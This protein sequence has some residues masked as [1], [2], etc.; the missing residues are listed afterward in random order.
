M[1]TPAARSSQVGR[2]RKSA[3]DSVSLVRPVLGMVRGGAPL[4]PGPGRA[5]R[6]SA[7]TRGDRR[8]LRWRRSGPRARKKNRGGSADRPGLNE[9]EDEGKAGQEEDRAGKDGGWAR[10]HTKRR[11]RQS[12]R[13]PPHAR[14]DTTAKAL[15]RAWQ[16]PGNRLSGGEA[17]ETGG[18]WPAKL[19]KRRQSL[20]ASPPMH[21]ARARL[22]CSASA[23]ELG[24]HH[25]LGIPARKVPVEHCDD[26]VGRD[27]QVPL[28]PVR[29]PVDH[30]R[31]NNDHT[32][33]HHGR[34]QGTEV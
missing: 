29:P 11:T 9:E 28:Q 30:H 4:V 20:S 24:S 25:R 14:K 10:R 7:A 26:Q 18:A 2:Q 13:A 22:A 31:E 34:V 15:E 12:P 19:G 23:S 21:R 6:A 8:T 1:G 27:Q 17:H 33:E 3:Q 16:W 32:D 5:G